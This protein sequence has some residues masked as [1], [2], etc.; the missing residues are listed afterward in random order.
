MVND[1]IL[2]L[3]E[4]GYLDAD[5]RSGA[6]GP[7]IHR[8]RR[9]TSDGHDFLAQIRDDTIFNQAKERVGKSVGSV[10]LTVFGEV[11]GAFAKGLLGLDGS[12]G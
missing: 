2:Q 3:I 9:L 12:A 5:G 11:A 1:H 10:S 8:I 6:K 7:V 4:K